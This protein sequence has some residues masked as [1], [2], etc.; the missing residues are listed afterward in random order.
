MIVAVFS[1]GYRMKDEGKQAPFT[2][3]DWL[4][5]VEYLKVREVCKGRT[6]FELTLL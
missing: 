4:V 3:L 5:S 2:A 1:V 6:I